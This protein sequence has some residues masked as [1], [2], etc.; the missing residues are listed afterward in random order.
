MKIIVVDNFN[1]ES[2]S[3]VLIAEKTPDYYADFITTAL[4]KKYSG[5]NSPDF[6]KVVEDDY[7]LYVFEP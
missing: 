4:N 3:D 7:K 5:D 2:V 6:F 1:R